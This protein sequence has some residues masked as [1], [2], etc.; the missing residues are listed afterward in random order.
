MSFAISE[1]TDELESACNAA[2]ELGIVLLC[3]THDEGLGVSTTYPASFHNTI[4]ITACDDY[5]KVLRP[6]PPSDTGSF[7]YKVQGQSVAAG[8]IP[9]LDSDDYISGSSVATAITAG[10][11]SL[12]LSCDRIAKDDPENPSSKGNQQ[13]SFQYERLKDYKAKT[14]RN[15]LKEMLAKESNDYI[16]LQK[17]GEIDKKIREGRD[18]EASEIITSYF[19]QSKF[20]EE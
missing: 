9:F 12:I 20:E 10:L 17:F 18:I 4:T 2:A 13:K 15:H 11:S 1:K 14:V 5:G 6:G 16:L 3:S 8:V 19:Q 7:Q